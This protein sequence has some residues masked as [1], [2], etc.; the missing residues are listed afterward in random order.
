MKCG[1][2]GSASTHTDIQLQPCLISLVYIK[3]LFPACILH[4]RA[5]FPSAQLHRENQ[6]CNG[7]NQRAERDDAFQQVG[8]WEPAITSMNPTETTTHLSKI[9]LAKPSK[10][11]NAKFKLG[12]TQ[13]DPNQLD[14]LRIWHRP[15]WC[16]KRITVH[17]IDMSHTHIYI[18]YIYIYIYA[19]VLLS[20]PSLAF[21]GVIIWA[22]FVFF[23][24]HCLSKKHYKNRGFS[25]FV[26][27]TKLR[28]QI[29]GVIIWAKLVIFKMQSTWPR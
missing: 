1:N 20:G 9:L 5:S 6:H 24:K 14:T 23:T 11:P 7:Y 4:T 21:W 29:W 12:N 17:N 26:F 27:E 15:L 25:T 8:Q 16:H 19:V 22:K 10:K 28:A 13:V 2:L 18:Y 3:L